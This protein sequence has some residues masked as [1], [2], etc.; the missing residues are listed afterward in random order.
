MSLEDLGHDR[1]YYKWSNTI[2]VTAT[3]PRERESQKPRPAGSPIH[4]IVM[5]G[6]LLEMSQIGIGNTASARSQ[7]RS[8]GSLGLIARDGPADALTSL[9]EM[10]HHKNINVTRHFLPIPQLS[11]R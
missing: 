6:N 9:Q 2:S 1:K 10:R 11:I 5:M 7:F 8:S 3:V 4:V